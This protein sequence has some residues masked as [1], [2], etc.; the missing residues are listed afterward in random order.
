M[1]RPFSLVLKVFSIDMTAGL[2]KKYFSTV[3]EL[4]SLGS[5]FY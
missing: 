3:I 2:V 5:I 4:S 1:N